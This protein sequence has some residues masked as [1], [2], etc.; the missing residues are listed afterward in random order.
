MI[1]IWNGVPELIIY[2]LLTYKNT[3]VKY[4]VVV[5]VKGGVFT[6]RRPG[7]ETFN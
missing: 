1:L 4:I 5:L 2:S 3:L 6:R 7:L